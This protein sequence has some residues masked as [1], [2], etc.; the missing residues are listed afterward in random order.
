MPCKDMFAWLAFA[1]AIYL[2][3]LTCLVLQFNVAHWV[4]LSASGS[5][6]RPE[7]VGWEAIVFYGVC[8][9]T[10]CI[11]KREYHQWDYSRKNGEAWYQYLLDLW[12]LIDLVGILLTGYSLF[13]IRLKSY[14]G[15]LSDVLPAWLCHDEDCRDHVRECQAIALLASWVK[16]LYFLRG[17]E[18]TAFVVNMLCAIVW[19]MRHFARVLLVLLAA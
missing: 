16:V 17:F 13:L 9:Y 12:N 10:L 8:I 18:E 15:E 4:D 1:Y 19:D 3:A 7:E 5:D 2:F 14:G 6:G 11:A